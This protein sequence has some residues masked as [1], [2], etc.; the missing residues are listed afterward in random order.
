[1]YSLEKRPKRFDQI[2]GQTAIINEFKNRA[3]NK[4]KFP[5]CIMLQG[6]TGSG[7]NTTAFII[8]KLLNCAS[9]VKS[10]Q[11]HF[12][13]CNECASCKDINNEKFSRDVKLL[14]CSLYG[15]GDITDLSTSARIAPMI[16]KNKIYILDEF[17]HLSGAAKSATK[18]LLEKPRR[19]TYFIACT[20]EI[21]TIVR[22]IRSR[23]QEYQYRKL[24]SS[25]ID[26]YLF[27]II[28]DKEDIPEEFIK[29][30]IH[31]ISFNAEGSLRTALTY[32]ERCIYGKLWTKEQIEKELDFFHE[33]TLLMNIYLLLNKSKE[34]LK[35]LLDIKNLDSFFYMSKVMLVNANIYKTIGSLREQWKEKEAK[36]MAQFDSLSDLLDIYF[37]SI[38]SKGYFDKSLFLYYL[39]KYYNQKKRK[40]A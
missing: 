27:N 6:E 5:Q 20:S 23:F 16:D 32:L 33:D 2:A 1:M 18:K 21:K 26:D 35:N 37:N 36:K 29:E 39:T 28:I 19:N 8:A 12:E 38:E 15:K 9:P 30:G 13:P 40:Q 34:G 22:E 25:I 14:D 10:N 11:G 4:I 31:I 7:K 3:T 17:Q 24:D